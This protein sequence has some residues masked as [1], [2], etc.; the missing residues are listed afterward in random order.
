V[1]NVT[2]SKETKE[3][4]TLAMSVPFE[5]GGKKLFRAELEMRKNPEQAY[6]VKFLSFC[7]GDISCLIEGG[8]TR[9][10]GL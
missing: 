9:I 4:E 6:I 10:N 5:Y 3:Q 1:P 7:Q 8:Q 2:W